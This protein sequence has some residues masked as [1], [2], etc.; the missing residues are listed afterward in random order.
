MKGGTHLSGKGGKSFRKKNKLTKR[1]A[2]RGT[3]LKKREKG[4]FSSSG[5]K[6]GPRK[7]GGGVKKK[8]KRHRWGEGVGVPGARGSRRG[9]RKGKSFEVKKN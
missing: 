1:S 3:T 6:K 7:Q 9:E 5:K 8:K 4:G 2:I